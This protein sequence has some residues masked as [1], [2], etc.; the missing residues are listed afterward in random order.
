L[1]DPCSA[2]NLYKTWGKIK[3]GWHIFFR[4]APLSTARRRRTIRSKNRQQA[5][6]NRE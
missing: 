1:D 5:V 2:G 4:T 6:K 3:A